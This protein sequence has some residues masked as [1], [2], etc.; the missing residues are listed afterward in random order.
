MKEKTNRVLLLTLEKCGSQWVRDVLSAPEIVA[1]SGCPHSGI[2]LNINSCNR[3]EIPAHTF[4]GPIYGMNQWEW[5]YWKHPGDKAVVVLRDP[6]DLMISLMFSWLYSHGSEARVDS[7]RR[8]LH[9]M[10]ND[11]KRVAYMIP[12]FGIGAR[13][14]M[15]WTWVE[16]VHEDALVLRYESLVANQHAEFGKVFDWLGWDVPKKTLD[17]VVDRLSFEARSGRKPGATD[18]FSHYRRGVSGDWRNYFTRQHGE[19]W[20][21]LSPGFLREIGYEESDDWWRDLPETLAVDV[22]GEPGDAGKADPQAA[23]IEALQTKQQQL[24]QELVD[25]ERVI[26][27]LLVE[28]AAKKVLTGVISFIARLTERLR[29]K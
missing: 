23:M 26:Q 15:Y 12:G 28:R 8:V 27:Q 4:S 1:I 5:Q 24:Q 11:E 18:K 25:K 6:R 9:D 19:Q 14:R 16:G 10:P 21:R 20:E 2:S 29:R 17:T 3:L 7:G 22:P 13:R